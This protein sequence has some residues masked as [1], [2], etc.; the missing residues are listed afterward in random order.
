MLIKSGNVF[1]NVKRDK[2]AKLSLRQKHERHTIYV[3]SALNAVASATESGLP[4]S[5]AIEIGK[6]QA[7]EAARNWADIARSGNAM[8][9]SFGVNFPTLSKKDS[10]K[11]KGQK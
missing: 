2:K 7:S 5:Q 4:A 9:A 3:N 11:P 10:L 1:V 8:A 6:K